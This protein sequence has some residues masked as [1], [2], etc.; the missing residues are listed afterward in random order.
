MIEREELD[1]VL[2]WIFSTTYTNIPWSMHLLPIVT[3][4]LLITI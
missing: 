2:C 4:L 3:R 1:R